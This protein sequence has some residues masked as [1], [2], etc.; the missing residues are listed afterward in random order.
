[1]GNEEKTVLNVNMFGGLAITYQGKNIS[2]GKNKTAKKPAATSND[3][4]SVQPDQDAALAAAIL[5]SNGEEVPQADV[6]APE[7]PRGENLS[8]TMK[9]NQEE[10][11][12]KNTVKKDEIVV[13]GV[14]YRVQFLTSDKPFADGAKE[15][16]GVSGYEMYEQEG[17]YRYT[18]GNEKTIAA[19]KS[20][21]TS[22][23]KKGF[24][25]A[26]VIAFNNGKRISMQEARELQ[27]EE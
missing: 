11:Q 19:A 1:M 2:I 17:L 8:G 20:I 12:L 22:L 3:D 23:R 16:K 9:I 25:D 7:K 18:M 21:Q 24:K 4:V 26:F 15:F 14:T 27:G 10:A 5:Q 6:E 13:E